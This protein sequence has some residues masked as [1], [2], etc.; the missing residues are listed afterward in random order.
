[1]PNPPT[2][3]EQWF[4]QYL[5]DHGYAFQIEPNLGIQKRPD[6]LI[7]RNGNSA[8]CE[9]K[10]PETDAMR[11]R[12]PEGGSQIGTFS[13]DEWLRNVRR[14][15][16]RAAR[17][18]AELEGDERPLVIVLAN[19]HRVGADIEGPKLIEAMQGDLTI[20]FDVDTQT[21]QSVSDPVW[22]LG[23]G[24]RLAGERAPWVSAVVGLHR[25]DRQRD[26]AQAWIE[27]WKAKHWP[28]GP[29]ADRETLFTQVLARGKEL[30][31]AMQCEDVPPGYYYRVDVVEAFSDT[32]VPL[33]RTIFDGERD[34]RW[35]VNRDR[36]TWDP[37]A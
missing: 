11:R 3:S 26:W 15:I 24:G 8:I 12:W 4:D 29:P 13:T 31:G 21:G 6:R 19:P 27:E 9:V 34:R 20:T 28:D 23:E 1:M 30:E 5:A 35:V 33:P 14:P 7:E 18:L 22:T 36:R 16:S 25:G 2:E 37:P 10:E 17:Q 32:A